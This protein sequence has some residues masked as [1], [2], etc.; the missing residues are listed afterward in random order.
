[1][2]LLILHIVIVYWILANSKFLKLDGVTSAW[3][4]L[5]IILKVVSGYF[6]G[7]YYLATYQGGD[8]QGYLLDAN[9]FFLLFQEHPMDFFKLIVGIEV[10]SETIQEFYTHLTSWFSSGY[11]TQYN[12]A[13]S[14]IRFHALIRLFSEGNEWIHLLWSNVL[15]VA[16]MIAM[17]QF[18]SF[19]NI[20]SIAFNR[21]ALL[22]LF[23]P[24]VFIWSSAILKEPLLIFALGMTLKYFQQFNES[25]NLSKAVGLMFF[26]LCF[27]LIKSFWLL[28][29]FPGL[30]IWFLM[31]NM[32]KAFLT[33]SISYAIA[34]LLVLVVGEFI[35]TFNLPD[36]IF[37]QQRN[38]W[39]FVVYMHSGSIIPPIAFA[40]NPLSFVSHLP[41]AFCNGM[42]QPWPWQL[43][44]WYFFPLTME[45]FVFPVLVA[46]VVY[47][48][49]SKLVPVRP[50]LMI[51]L[52]S[53]IT[54]VIV[55]AFTTPVIGSLIRYRMPGL[56]LMVLAVTAYLFSL[57][58]KSSDNP[59]N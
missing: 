28:A 16:G 48:I 14:V 29:L 38:M 37:G 31:P 33:I 52:L 4:A 30:L 35:V 23:L 42:F 53:G 45:N 10:K 18:I 27:L 19:K 24:N 22:I 39:R 36:L 43:T 40:P 11:S 44:K 58:A 51:A 46:A 41:E 26:V 59:A 7:R 9:Q 20:E 15:C 2:L 3:M 50:A 1:M 55:S 13:R 17:I 34:L 6:V 49:R 21:W 8:I 56:L 54:I 12:D 47:K 5:V 25:R 32:K 57:K